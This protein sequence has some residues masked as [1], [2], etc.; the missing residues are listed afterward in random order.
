M[1]S[2]S[3]SAGKVAAKEVDWKEARLVEFLKDYPGEPV[4]Q[5]GGENWQY[6]WC[7]YPNGRTDVG[8]YRFY[9]DV[10]YGYTHFQR[11]WLGLI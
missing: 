9:E 1:L 7:T 6:C 8:V 3:L 10:C 4:F 2:L 5:H 11:D